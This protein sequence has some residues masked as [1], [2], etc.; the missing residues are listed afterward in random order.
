MNQEQV[1]IRCLLLSSESEC[2]V[3]PAANVAEITSFVPPRP[4]DGLP[5]WILGKITWRDQLVPVLCLDATRRIAGKES[6]RASKSRITI[7]ILYGLQEQ[8]Q[9]PFY[10]VKVASV[11][12]PI[13]LLAHDVTAVGTPSDTDP[14]RIAAVKIGDIEANIP[15]LSALESSLR[16]YF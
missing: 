11:P 6:F 3:I 10:G 4:I 13:S 15:N 9:L 7:V 14:L 8:S 16:K 1:H 12:R 5:S 2:I